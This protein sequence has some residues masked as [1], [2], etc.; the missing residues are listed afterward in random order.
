MAGER[1]VVA[2]MIAVFQTA[3]VLA[4]VLAIV[5]VSVGIFAT[6]YLGYFILPFTFVLIALS[7]VGM[8]NLLKQ[9][10]RFR[11]RRRNDT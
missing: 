3:V 5:A 11:G 6:A 8:S 1:S 7:I 4:R 9:W 2:H 10:S